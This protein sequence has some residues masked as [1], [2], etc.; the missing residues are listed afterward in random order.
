MAAVLNHEYD[1]VIESAL[2]VDCRFP[3]EYDGGH[4]RVSILRRRGVIKISTTD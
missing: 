2:V 1:H 4:I 3:Y